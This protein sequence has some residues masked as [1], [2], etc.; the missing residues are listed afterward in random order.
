MAQ[1]ILQL[2]K[3]VAY[4]EYAPGICT[5]RLLKQ[6]PDLILRRRQRLRIGS[7]RHKH[8]QIAEMHQQF[9]GEPAHI[10]ACRIK[11]FNRRKNGRRIAIEN[12]T[13]EILKLAAAYQSKDPEGILFAN[14]VALEGDEL[15]ERRKR[16][17]HSPL[18]TTGDGKQ[19]ILGGIDFFK[20]A[21]MLEPRNDVVGLDAP[22]V[23]TLA[24]RNNRRQYLVAFGCREDEAHVWRRLLKR[25]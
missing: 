4:A 19:R 3:L 7:K 14:L 15:I 16:V 25:L 12:G 20:F 8:H 23:K 11:S 21:N 2:R 9:A 24:T 5:L 18:R 1:L 22:K 6:N 13:G 10:L 17:S